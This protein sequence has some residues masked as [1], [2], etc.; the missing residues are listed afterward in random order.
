MKI[1][2]HGKTYIVGNKY[3]IV[4]V[5]RQEDGEYHPRKVLAKL[6]FHEYSDAE[7]YAVSD[8]Y[9]LEFIYPR[10]WHNVE[11]QE[12]KTFPDAI[13]STENKVAK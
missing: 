10:T 7:G 3:N 4:I 11:R 9:G 2:Y 6:V 12:A 13:W 5:E 1:Q 8:H